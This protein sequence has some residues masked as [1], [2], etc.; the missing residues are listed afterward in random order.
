MNAG[1][2]KLFRVPDGEL[3]SVNRYASLIGHFEFHCGRPQRPRCF[4]GFD[5]LLHR[6]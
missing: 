4:D 5:N 3:D 1:F 2:R 6:F